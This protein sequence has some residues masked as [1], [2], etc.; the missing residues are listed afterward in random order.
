[1]LDQFDDDTNRDDDEDD[2][3]ALCPYPPHSGCC[4]CGRIWFG[5]L[6]SRAPALALHYTSTYPCPAFV[7]YFQALSN[8][9]LSLPHSKLK[10]WLSN[11]DLPSYHTTS[12]MKILQN[13]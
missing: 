3:V 7:K 13:G 9:K 8:P 5:N 4:G 2:G 10:F 6:S 1:M 12:R 11:D